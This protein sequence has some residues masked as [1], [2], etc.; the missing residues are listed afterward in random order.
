MTVPYLAGAHTSA[1][2]AAVR[3]LWSLVGDGH[4]PDEGLKFSAGGLLLSPY[5]V[6]HGGD[7]SAFDGSLDPTDLDSDAWP[8]VQVTYIG[9]SRA[10]ADTLRDLVR[11]GLLG[12]Y[13]DIAGRKAGPV[14][15]ELE[16]RV[17]RDEKVQPALYYAIDQYRTYTTPN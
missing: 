8:I 11:A 14:R 17:Q 3:D 16:R 1:F 13:L 9:G 6:V 15:L 5:C 12:Q 10:H 4:E 2:L 7:T